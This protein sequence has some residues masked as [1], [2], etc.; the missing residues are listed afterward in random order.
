MLSLNAMQTELVPHSQPKIWWKIPK[1]GLDSKDSSF[2][3]VC[4]QE[5]QLETALTSERSSVT[6]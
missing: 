6:L 3:D 4:R 5:I 1:I 2:L